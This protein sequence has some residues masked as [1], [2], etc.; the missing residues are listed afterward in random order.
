[1][2]QNSNLQSMLNEYD[3]KTEKN[4]QNTNPMFEGEINSRVLEEVARNLAGLKEYVLLTITPEIMR[5]TS[6]QT[7]GAE[8]ETIAQT[9]EIPAKEWESYSLTG[10][11]SYTAI[12][13]PYQGI[14]K[15]F[16]GTSCEETIR[17][18]C[19]PAHDNGVLMSAKEHEMFTSGTKAKNSTKQVL[20]VLSVGEVQTVT[21][22]NPKYDNFELGDLNHDSVIQFKNTFKVKQWIRNGDGTDSE[23]VILIALS[24][25]GNSETESAIVSFTKF[26]IETGTVDD[27]LVLGENDEIQHVRTTNETKFDHEFVTELLPEA[28]EC[29]ELINFA[30][31]DESLVKGIFKHVLKDSLEMGEYEIC[32]S[33]QEPLQ[34]SHNINSVTDVE[35]VSITTN[36]IAPV[37][38]ERLNC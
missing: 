15:A 33:H 23:S 31:Y 36:T 32:F 7:P 11:D 5:F 25:R 6:L 16:T 22:R 21:L 24:T 13:Q 1:M 28:H 14:V 8:V 35:T 34:M 30:F 20:D 27:S 26:C 19:T 4:E 10:G 18:S 9:G 37:V 2:R 17:V 38:V 3:E 12:I 29:D